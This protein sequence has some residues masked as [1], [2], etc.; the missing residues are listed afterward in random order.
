MVP[1]VAIFADL[2]FIVLY[3]RQSRFAWHVAVA[4]NLALAIYRLGGGRQ[5]RADIIVYTILLVYL[6]VLRQVYFDYINAHA[7]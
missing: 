6:F 4:L 2:L 5:L 7:T 1:V 3:V